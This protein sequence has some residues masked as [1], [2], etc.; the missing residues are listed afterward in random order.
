MLMKLKPPK[1]QNCRLTLLS[2]LAENMILSSIVLQLLTNITAHCIAII[3]WS[4]TRKRLWNQ[5]AHWQIW[6]RTPC[7]AH[8]P[9]ACS[10]CHQKQE[11]ELSLCHT[12]NPFCFLQTMAYST[13]TVFTKNPLPT[14]EFRALGCIPLSGWCC[15]WVSASVG[16]CLIQGLSLL[17]VGLT[18]QA[19]WALPTLSPMS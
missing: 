10:W 19:S 8:Q 9:A 7:D 18:G 15:Y 11:N 4:G 12:S 17:W 5:C 13:M 16:T 1:N 3:N 6:T 14:L 2:K